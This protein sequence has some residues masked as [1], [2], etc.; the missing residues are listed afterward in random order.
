MA[1]IYYDEK[2][3]MIIVKGLQV[4][5]GKSDLKY[6]RF[7]GGDDGKQNF[8]IKISDEDA[9][10][11]VEDITRAG[12]F[13]NIKSDKYDKFFKVNLGLRTNIVRFNEGKTKGT[14]YE[15]DDTKLMSAIDHT[16]IADGEISCMPYY[17]NKYKQWTCYLNAMWFV[18]IVDPVQAMIDAA[19]CESPS[20]DDDEVSF[21]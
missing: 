13:I 20:E 9:E 19:E 7:A 11:L 18:P 2:T 15:S 3:G 21:E 17:S 10:Q 5:P 12:K 4:M 1:K 8:C 6:K 14:P 16:M